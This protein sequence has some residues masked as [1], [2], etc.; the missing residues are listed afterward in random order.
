MRKRKTPL[1]SYF[2]KPITTNSTVKNENA[3]MMV[4]A[5]DQPIGHNA[6]NLSSVDMPPPEQN[7][8]ASVEVIEQQRIGST[9]FERDPGK[10]KQ[11]WELPLEKQNEARQFYIC[12]GRYMPYMREYPYND[13]PTKHRR[14]FQYSWFKDF[15]W[16]EFSPY[17]KRAYCF[18]C[19]L[20]S[21][22]PIGKCG[23][24]AS[25]WA[26]IGGRR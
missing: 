24:K 6:T 10:C 22:K 26:L 11:I 8:E 21:R 18:H 4:D 2:F 7:I 15:Q 14:R 12:D 9:P 3:T 19:F 23:C 17:T 25:Y 20:F 1:I 5:I 13:D 16:L